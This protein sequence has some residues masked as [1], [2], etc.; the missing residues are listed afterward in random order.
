M[1]IYPATPGDL[2]RIKAAA[3]A[4]HHPAFAPTHFGQD[5]SG[6]VKGY[7]SVGGLTAVM[8]WSHTGN[9]PIE[10]LRLVKASQHLARQTGKP[11]IYPCSQKSPFAPLLPDL[12]FEKLGNADLW[13]LF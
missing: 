3:A 9:S 10:S 5:A 7:F 6:Q 13:K 4:D 8:F 2:D 1:K 12:G 11:V